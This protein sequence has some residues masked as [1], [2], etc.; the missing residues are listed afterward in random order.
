[1]K[2]CERLDS[3]APFRVMD[4]AVE[5]ESGFDGGVGSRRH[6]GFGLGWVGERGNEFC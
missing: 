3:A 2:D 6:F 1:M 4:S 5:F